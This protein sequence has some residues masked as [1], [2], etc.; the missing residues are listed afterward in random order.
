MHRV[1][2]LFSPLA[3]QS[4]SSQIYTIMD[5][6]KL[7]GKPLDWPVQ[8]TSVRQTGQSDGVSSPHPFTLSQYQPTIIIII[9]QRERQHVK[10]KIWKNTVQVSPVVQ[11]FG[12]VQRDDDNGLSTYY[13]FG[14]KRVIWA[15]GYTQVNERNGHENCQSK[16]PNQRPVWLMPV[17][18]MD[19]RRG[20]SNILPFTTHVL[21]ITLPW[22]C[23]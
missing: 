20:S 3:R 8:R 10:K 6:D 9:A 19:I 17:S 13:C 5:R 16:V 1:L 22:K 21:I 18:W 2:A 14:I 11:I 7:V 4:A 23:F 15:M 12:Y